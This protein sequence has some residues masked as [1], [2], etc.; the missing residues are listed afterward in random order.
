[1]RNNIYI[2][3]IILI[4]IIYYLLSK[5]GEKVEKD[6]FNTTVKPD[7][8]EVIDFIESK[9]N[10][11]N[12]K[13][14]DNLKKCNS[15]LE[16]SRFEKD[17]EKIQQYNSELENIKNNI[18][19]INYTIKQYKYNRDINP[20]D[21]ESY[22]RLIN[23]EEIKRKIEEDKNE[24]IKKKLRKEVLGKFVFVKMKDTE[25]CIFKENEKILSDEINVFNTK[26]DSMIKYN[27]SDSHNLNKLFYDAQTNFKEYQKK[28]DQQDHKLYNYH[29]QNV[30]NLVEDKFRKDNILFNNKFSIHENFGDTCETSY[31]DEDNYFKK[32]LV[33][34]YQYK[35]F[36][37]IYFEIKKEVMIDY[38]KLDLFLNYK[39]KK[40]LY[41]SKNTIDIKSRIEQI[42]KEIEKEIEKINQEILNIKI[43]ED[44]NAKISDEINKLNSDH[45]KEYFNK[46]YE[47]SRV[48]TKDNIKNIE[49]NYVMEVRF[50]PKVNKKF[51]VNLNFNNLITHIE[52][53]SFVINIIKDNQTTQITAKI[54][55]LINKEIIV[56]EMKELKNNIIN[57]ISKSYNNDNLYNE[58]NVVLE[59]FVKK[60]NSIKKEL[61]HKNINK[62]KINIHYE[63]VFNKLIDGIKQETLQY[64]FKDNNGKKI[65]NTDNVNISL[66]NNP[67]E[68]NNIF[69]IKYLLNT[70]SFNE[71]Y[72][73]ENNYN[74]IVNGF[75]F[76]ILKTFNS[77]VNAEKYIVTK[78]MYSILNEIGFKNNFIFII[79]LTNCNYNKTY[80]LNSGSVFNK[81]DDKYD[82]LSVEQ[83][84]HLYTLYDT[85][86]NQLLSM[87][88]V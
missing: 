62:H 84:K 60:M 63:N 28:I 67:E 13:H 81:K 52:K 18:E 35:N 14:L 72:D 58:I 61:I 42:K 9:T 65:L 31:T 7:T 3:I 44:K 78:D 68:N 82:L 29:I 4:L 21:K 54:M 64:L 73:N 50:N 70:P 49:L 69:L 55:D 6:N 57:I 24:E 23:E 48:L 46:D 83:G 79:Y 27:S 76:T 22:N 53:L 32:Y 80:N 74:S 20:E 47:N 86:G 8:M 36:N 17:N 45:L 39:L 88:N 51:L 34:P 25:E 2:F 71:N 19:K 43:G 87:K 37:H 41:S 77:N 66:V 59:S 1:M 40:E 38:E 15:S 33:L 11:L 85:Y 30:Y 56:K 75:K 10:E 26:L 5:G 12:A 16:I